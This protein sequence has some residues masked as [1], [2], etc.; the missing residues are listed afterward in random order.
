MNL[1]RL[2]PTGADGQLL[3]VIES[4]QEKNETSWPTIPSKDP[5]DDEPAAG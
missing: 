1:E 2:S 5:G 4:P 3:A